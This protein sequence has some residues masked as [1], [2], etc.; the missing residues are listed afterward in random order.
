M[1]SLQWEGFGSLQGVNITEKGIVVDRIPHKDITVATGRVE[2]IIAQSIGRENYEFN[3][4]KTPDL[5]QERWEEV[6]GKGK[7]REIRIGAMVLQPF[8]ADGGAFGV[9]NYLMSREERTPLQIV[10]A[11]NG[12]TA[13]EIYSD[14]LPFDPLSVQHVAMQTGLG[15]VFEFDRAKNIV[16]QVSPSQ[17]FRVF[18][19]HSKGYL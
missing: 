16:A 12:D 5:L 8:I 9:G 10:V 14:K 7:P 1:A 17:S 3:E 11:Y 4:F 2:E 18:T 15:S 13:E 6:N 19:G